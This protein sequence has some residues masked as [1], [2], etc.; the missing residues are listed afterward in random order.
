MIELEKLNGF[1]RNH[2]ALRTGKGLVSGVIALTRWPFC[3]CWGVLAFTPQ[4]LTTPEA[5]QGYDVNVIRT[6]MLAAMAIAG[7][8]RWSTSCSTAPGGWQR[9]PSPWWRLAALCWAAGHKV[10]VG[11]TSG[12]TPCIG[13][14][15]FILDL[16]R[17]LARLHQQ[18]KA[19]GTHRRRVARVRAPSRP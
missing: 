1:T 4:Y 19:V 6:I 14:D 2:G 8:S 16:L 18:V 15:W 12:C 5:A 7:V 3:A 10:E 9:S 13:L 17:Q 11:T